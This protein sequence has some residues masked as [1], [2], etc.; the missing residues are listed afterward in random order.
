MLSSY[1]TCLARQYHKCKYG[2]LYIHHWH[3]YS[4]KRELCSPLLPNPWCS[5]IFQVPDTN[6]LCCMRCF[7]WACCS[8]HLTSP[9]CSH[10]HWVVCTLCSHSCY[11]W[12][13]WGYRLTIPHYQKHICRL[14]L[15]SFHRS[16]TPCGRQSRCKYI[17]P[18]QQGLHLH[19]KF[20][21]LS[22]VQV[23]AI[24]VNI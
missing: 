3:T 4:G 12:G 19:A 8:S 15:G 13:W 2:E 18:I 6:H 20:F 1:K 10:T 16:H 22:I 9:H 5:S 21:T 17:S 7:M 14:F 11:I 23:A 24:V